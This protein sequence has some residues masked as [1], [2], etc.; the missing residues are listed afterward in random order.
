M[1]VVCVSFALLSSLSGSRF[2][3]CGDARPF[4]WIALVEL[5]L[6]TFL[7]MAWRKDRG[8]CEQKRSAECKA[9][10][11]FRSD[12]LAK[13]PSPCH[14][15]RVHAKHY[16]LQELHS[17]MS[18]SAPESPSSSASS[19]C[20]SDGGTSSP[21]S[22]SACSEGPA[23]IYV[24]SPMR[25]KWSRKCYMARKRRH[26]CP[27][28]GRPSED[29]LANPMN[30]DCAGGH[31]NFIASVKQRVSQQLMPA[32][33]KQHVARQT[34][35]YLPREGFDAIQA[36]RRVTH[37][38]ISIQEMIACTERILEEHMT[39]HPPSQRRHSDP[40]IPVSGCAGSF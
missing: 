34:M 13:V 17:A 25:A 7:G 38:A 19:L 32:M 6:V 39:L 33:L 35:R 1:A 4:L 36:R 24:K 21:F 5:V 11:A 22:S 30:G 16:P 15:T 12:P 20:S 40:G 28:T 18:E 27:S 2:L 9:M 8:V 26:S 23:V 37:Q 31:I 10:P 3:A 29:Q 14:E